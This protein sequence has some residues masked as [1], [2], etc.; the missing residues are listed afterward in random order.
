MPRDIHTREEVKAE[1]RNWHYWG[2]PKIDITHGST[3][4]GEIK[5]RN[6]FSSVH[7]R[8]Q[9]YWYHSISDHP[10]I[11]RACSVT[12]NIALLALR[13]CHQDKRYQTNKCVHITQ[14]NVTADRGG[15]LTLMCHACHC[16]VRVTECHDVQVTEWSVTASDS[17]APPC[18]IPALL[19]RWPPEPGMGEYSSKKSLSYYKL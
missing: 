12:L 13:I 14:E 4:Q 3:E 17:G 1:I 8:Q 11:L 10:S 19:P 6:M 18:L 2:L 9:I 16:H 15:V 7:T 5:W